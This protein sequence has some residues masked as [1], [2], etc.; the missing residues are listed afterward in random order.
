MN[1]K[2][3]YEDR[4]NRTRHPRELRLANLIK[5]TNKRTNWVGYKLEKNGKLVM[6]AASCQMTP[7]FVALIAEIGSLLRLEKS[8]LI[9]DQYANV[10]VTHLV[11]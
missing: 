5:Q 1:R 4:R 10:F 9:F 11:K 2:Q 7:P 3:K 6:H 8:M